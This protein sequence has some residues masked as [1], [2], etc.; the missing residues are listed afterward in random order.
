MRIGINEVL[1]NPCSSGAVNR[2]VSV[3]PEVLK[4]IEANGGESIVYISKNL[5][6]LIINRLVDGAKKVHIIRTPLPFTPTYQRVLKGIRYWPKRASKDKLDVF[7][8]AYY[9]VPRLKIPTVLTVHDVRFVHMPETYRRARY[10]FLRYSVPYSLAVATRIITISENTKNDLINYFGIPSKK[11]DTSY[12]PLLPNF[13]RT[14][15]DKNTNLAEIKNRLKLPKK[16]IL[17]V[18]NLEPRKNLSRLL[19]AFTLVRQKASCKLVIVGKPAWGTNVLFDTVKQNHLENEL[20]FTGYLEEE[21]LCSVYR[22]ASMLAFPSLH[23]G[24]G[25]P[26]IEAMA[27]GT[28]VLTSNVSALPEVAGDA[29]ILVDPYSVKSIANG[30]LAILSDEKLRYRLIEKGFERIKVFNRKESAKAV[31][32]SYKKAFT[33]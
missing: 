23:E 22:L 17:Y 1:I 27:C 4:Q 7:H 5:D 2:E 29:A 13:V 3:L 28:P 31:V 15:T 26:V 16:F 12:V 9:P 8:T 11:I 30:I 24:F 20:I 18:G 10:W 21:D 25:I 6:D 32:E 19:K 14:K 33:G